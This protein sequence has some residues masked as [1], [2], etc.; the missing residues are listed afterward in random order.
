MHELYDHKP[1]IEAVEKVVKEFTYPLKHKD[2]RFLPIQSAASVGFEYL[3]VLAK[4]G[5]K[6]EVG[7]EDARGGLLTADPSDA[8][9]QNALQDFVNSGA[10]D[11][12]EED[13]KM[14]DVLKELREADLLK[15]ED[16]LKQNLLLYS[17]LS[18]SKARF[19]Y[20]VS[21]DPDALIETKV[22]N[23]SLIHFFSSCKSEE[24][25]EIVK[26][27]L[28]SGFKYHAN[29]GGL[30]FIKDNHGTTA[31]DCMCNEK[32]VEKVMSMLHDMLSTKRGFP[33][34]HHVFVKA[35][36]HILTFLQKFPWAYDLKDHNART[37]H[38]AVLAAAP[39]VMKKN[40]MILASL[41]DNQIQTKDPVTTLYPFA[42]MAVGEHA[43]LETTFH[44]LRR[45]PS[46]MDRYLTSDIDDSSNRSRKKR[47]IG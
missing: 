7:G 10:Y 8:D 35:P 39:D 46:V 29:I 3:P 5:I 17:C 19:E 28:K 27:L 34:L 13:V 21:I 16:I 25:E 9:E 47:R 44:L 43:D 4:A 1:S 20:L 14:L 42:A 24:T 31:F 6:H 11:D 15:K 12:D 18:L 33:I 30:L 40:H 23:T 2:G 32:G 36:Q 37:L 22:R 38:Q 45:Q 41:S 26:L